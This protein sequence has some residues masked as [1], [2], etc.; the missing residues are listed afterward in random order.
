MTAAIAALDV[1]YLRVE[2]AAQRI[3][4][5]LGRLPAVDI[6]PDMAAAA[7]AVTWSEAQWHLEV[8]AEEQL[9]ENLPPDAARAE[10]YR[11]SDIARSHACSWSERE[12][13]IE[14]RSEA[15]RRLCDWMLSTASACQLMLTPLQATLPRTYAFT[16]SEPLPFGDAAG[17]RAWLGAQQLNLMAGLRAAAQAGWKDTAW[18]LAD[19]MGPLLCLLHPYDLWMEAHQIGRDAA[20]EAGNPA[21]ERRMLNS[22]ATGLNSAGR[23]R[24]A[25]AWYTASLEAARTAGDMRD[26]GQILLALGTCYSELGQP[27]EATSC[28]ELA[29]KCW[30]KCGYPRGV[31]LAA[32][33]LG[34][35]ALAANDLQRAVELFHRAHEILIDAGEQVDAERA[36]A[37]RG[38]ARVRS[39][40]Y[41]TGTADL[42]HALSEFEHAGGTRLRARTLDMLGSASRDHGEVAA[43][44]HY[45]Q[46]ATELYGEFSPDD[47][48]RMAQML[49]AL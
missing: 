15:M 31:A 40:D 30:K 37:L 21:A 48:A 39:G 3:Y 14:A 47:A 43:A 7:A 36:R 19:A 18:M 17:A 35:I 20:R 29:T 24:E 42:R 2:P 26:E 33:V 46:A 38:H 16:P 4:R 45:F 6:D 10:R 9:I 49:E 8:L 11:L 23:V 44:L 27:E 41:A 12:D 25:I 34:E 28:L 5:F 32:I 1:S 22:G 13:T